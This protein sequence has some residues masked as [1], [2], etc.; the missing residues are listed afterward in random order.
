MRR[1]HPRGKTAAC[2]GYVLSCVR[3]FVT[4]ET[5]PPGSSVLGF[6]RQEYARA[7]P[8]FL[9]GDLPTSPG[10]R[11]V[12][13]KP[14]A[15]AVDS[16]SL[17]ILPRLGAIK[18]R[19]GGG[20]WAAARPR[21]VCPMPGGGREAWAGRCRGSGAHTCPNVGGLSHEG[22]LTCRLLSPGEASLCSRWG[23][24]KPPCPVP[25]HRELPSSPSPVPPGS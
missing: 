14:L 18:E 8:F 1:S 3:L 2:R 12:S 15:L 25:R 10:I 17:G 5:S 21:L 6:S 23:R 22:A 11:P 13:P 7:Q 16:A 24:M 20:V 19:G 9:P 4:Q